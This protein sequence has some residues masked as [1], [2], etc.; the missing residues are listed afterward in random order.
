[1]VMCV[2]VK[3]FVLFSS[4]SC[5]DCL[6]TQGACGWC[7]YGGIC[8]GISEPCPV[9]EG[10]NNSYLKVSSQSCVKHWAIC[11]IFPSQLGTSSEPT[12]VCPVVNEAPT[13]GNYTQPVNVA[14]DLVLQTSNLPSPVSWDKIQWCRVAFGMAIYSAGWWFPLWVH[15]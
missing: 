1:M 10:V 5:V 15:Y 2:L 14:R 3:F 7:L 4:L 6:G 8:S 9:P 13:T 12:E 11:L